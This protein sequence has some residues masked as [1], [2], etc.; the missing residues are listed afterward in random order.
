MAKTTTNKETWE[1]RSD[2]TI[3]TNRRALHEYFVLDSLEV[4]IALTGTEIKS[5]RAGKVQLA[6]AY[7]RVDN[8]ELWLIGSHVSP[9]THG[10]YLNHDPDR[11]RKLLARRDQIEALR[12]G[13]QQKGQTLIP[14][15]IYLKHGRAKVELGLCKGKNLHDKRDSTAERDAKRDIER[16]IRGRD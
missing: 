12:A 8:G 1:R 7:A 14:I 13:V 2:R 10:N 16:A 15:K 6:D 3:V 9:Y 11:P 4:G 5:I